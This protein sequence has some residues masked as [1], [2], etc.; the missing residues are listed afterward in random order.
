MARKEV[1]VKKYVVRLGAEERA[2]LAAFIGAGK[3]S[4]R[5]LTKA[6]TLCNRCEPL[7]LYPPGDCRL[8]ALN[9]LR[10]LKG[11]VKNVLKDRN[12]ISGGDHHWG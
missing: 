3:R 5:L 11:A 10:D 2:Q 12:G 9:D 6:R 1:A 8:A 7:S 4:A